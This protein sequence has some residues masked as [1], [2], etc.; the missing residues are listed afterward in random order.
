MPHLVEELSENLKDSS[1]KLT[2]AHQPAF[3]PLPRTPEVP[4]EEPSALLPREASRGEMVRAESLQGHKFCFQYRDIFR[5][6]IMLLFIFIM[7]TMM[8]WRSKF[9]DA[10]RESFSFPFDQ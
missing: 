3:S 2:D 5:F 7:S 10:K 6:N 9:Q 4:E 1:S 8:L